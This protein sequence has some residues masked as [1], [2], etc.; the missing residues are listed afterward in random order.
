MFYVQRIVSGDEESLVYFNHLLFLQM[1]KLE[2]LIK[3]KCYEQHKPKFILMLSTLMDDVY[4]VSSFSEFDKF[5]CVFCEFMKWIMKSTKNRIIQKPEEKCILELLQKTEQNAGISIIEREKICDGIIDRIYPDNHIDF[6]F[7]LIGNRFIDFFMS[8][9]V[10]IKTFLGIS[11]WLWFCRYTNT[12]AM[13]FVNGKNIIGFLAWIFIM[14]FTIQKIIRG[15]DNKDIKDTV[16]DLS[17]AIEQNKQKNREYIKNKLENPE[18]SELRIDK[19]KLYRYRA[20]WLLKEFQIILLQEINKFTEKLIRESKIS[21]NMDS[22]FVKRMGNLKNKISNRDRNLE[23]LKES[24]D[25]FYLDIYNSFYYS[26]YIFCTFTMLYNIVNAIEINAENLQQSITNNE[27]IIEPREI[28][29][30]VN[31]KNKDENISRDENIAAILNN[32]YQG[33]NIPM[34]EK[35]EDVLNLV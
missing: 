29:E 12:N 18:N 32:V 27:I 22:G 30:F 6:L 14:H 17:K 15:I 3:E 23:D 4:Q 8:R 11:M 31:R 33:E 28:F 26:D 19:N 25:K 9:N 1:L 10:L 16:N 13:R 21:G 24:L 35:D 7:N 2:I 34:Q 5:C 20:G